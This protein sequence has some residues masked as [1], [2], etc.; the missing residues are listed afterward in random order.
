MHVTGLR[1]RKESYGHSTELKKKV[2]DRE[3]TVN[4]LKPWPIIWILF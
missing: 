2:V 4:A 1:N 3:W